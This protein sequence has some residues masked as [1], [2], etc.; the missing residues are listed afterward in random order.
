VVDTARL[1]HLDL[2]IHLVDGRLETDLYAKDVPNYVSRRSCHPPATFS[3]VATAVARRLRLNCSLERFL[4]PRIEEYTRYLMASDYTRSEVEVAMEEARGLDRDELVR[5]P[6]RGAAGGGGRKH[7]LLTTWD[8]RAPN[9]KEG[10]KRFEEILYLSEDNR[11]VYP[12]G[13]IMPGFR[14]GR[15]LGETIAPT[16][17]QRERVEREEGGCYACSSRRCQLHQSGALQEVTSVRSRWDGQVVRLLIRQDCATKH[18]VYRILCPCGHSVDYVG[19]ADTMK[20]RWSKHMS[21]IRFGHWDACG[22]TDH[23]R[24]HHQG[25]LEAALSNLQVTILDHLKGPYSEDR[26]RELEQGWMYKL[27][28]YHRTGCNTRQELVSSSRRTWGNVR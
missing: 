8:P 17:P 7:V 23:F 20:R 3:S 14:R 10:L 19:S 24:R 2:T 11:E 13:S 18:V 4:S 1:E 21:D 15:N 6:R 12:R 28:T 27:G 25:D 16:R 5:R 22:L 9:V 26:L